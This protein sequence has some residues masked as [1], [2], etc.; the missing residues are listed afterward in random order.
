MAFYKDILEL[1]ITWAIN[2]LMFISTDMKGKI[3]SDSLGFHYGLIKFSMSSQNE[4]DRHSNFVFEKDGS[5][6][7][8]DFDG[9]YS[10]GGPLG[11]SGVEK[12]W[13]YYN[14]LEVE[15]DL[16]NRLEVNGYLL[17]VGCG[18]GFAANYL[19]AVKINV[20]GMDISHEAIRFCQG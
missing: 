11:S 12:E 3:S 17:E 4:D 13:G 16:L 5:L 20:S 9:L 8:G 19:S 7:I 10:V 18:A 6:F 15:R 2:R 1:G 14:F